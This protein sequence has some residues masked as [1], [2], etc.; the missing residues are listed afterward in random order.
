MPRCVHRG[1][2]ENPFLPIVDTADTHNLS[3]P[4]FDVFIAAL[5][6]YDDTLDRFVDIHASWCCP[7]RCFI[8]FF[9]HII[10]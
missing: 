9:C 1:S 4:R 10:Q 3:Q 7:Y 5:A 2:T 8:R 6:E